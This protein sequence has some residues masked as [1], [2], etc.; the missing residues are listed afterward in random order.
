MS[1]NSTINFPKYHSPYISDIKPNLTR[2]E[3][4]TSYLNEFYRKYKSMLN[5]ITS[6]KEERQI[7]EKK[8]ESLLS[9][10]NSDELIK[11]LDELKKYKNNL[12]NSINCI[13]K[14]IRENILILDICRLF[15]CE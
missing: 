10:I 7:T 6:L 13:E 5:T 1:N 2:Y 4:I 3:H 9:D 15:N 14:D 12:N 11:Q 8:L